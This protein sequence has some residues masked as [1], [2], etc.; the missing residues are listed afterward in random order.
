M[1]APVPPLLWSLGRG[2][3]HAE[4]RQLGKFVG[5]LTV[6]RGVDGPLVARRYVTLAGNPLGDWEA[7]AA[8]LWNAAEAARPAAEERPA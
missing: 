4:V 1:S 2:G 3:M 8:E 6:L 5:E 7:S